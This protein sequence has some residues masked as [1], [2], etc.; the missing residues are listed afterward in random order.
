M[1]L[2]SL[3]DSYS[4]A[5]NWLVS[6]LICERTLLKIRKV[7]VIICYY[8]SVLCLNGNSSHSIIQSYLSYILLDNKFSPIVHAPAQKDH[9]S[10]PKGPPFR[11]KRTTVP[12]QKDHHSVSKGPPFRFKRTTVPFQKDHRSVSKGPP[13]RFKRTTIPSQK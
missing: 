7:F 5:S 2:I 6:W 10:V 1:Y 11:S 4:F 13:F 12:F 3:N 9:R 8:L